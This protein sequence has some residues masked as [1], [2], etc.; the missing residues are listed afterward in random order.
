MAPH[1]MKSHQISMRNIF[2]T[3]RKE[4]TIGSMLFKAM[5]KR[6]RNKSAT[7]WS[8]K[9]TNIFERIAV[10]LRILTIQLL[11]HSLLFIL[12]TVSHVRHRWKRKRGG[13]FITKPCKQALDDAC[14]K[15]YETGS[16]EKHVCDRIKLHCLA[17]Y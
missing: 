4:N 11:Y 2:M 3:R 14:A 6:H 12:S 9:T 15:L 8:C 17:L 10:N 5:E 7:S 16:A 1:A 13:N